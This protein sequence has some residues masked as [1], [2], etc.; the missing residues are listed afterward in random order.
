MKVRRVALQCEEYVRHIRPRRPH[1]LVH[2]MRYSDKQGSE[3]FRKFNPPLSLLNDA[4]F[5][6]IYDGSITSVGLT[7]HVGIVTVLSLSERAE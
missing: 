2:Q 3:P 4:E 5:E 1:T 6:G 7:T